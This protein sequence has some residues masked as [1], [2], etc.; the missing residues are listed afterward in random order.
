MRSRSI[1]P[2]CLRG[3]PDGAHCCGLS[4]HHTQTRFLWLPLPSKSPSTTRRRGQGVESVPH[5]PITK[6][7]H[8]PLCIRQCHASDCTHTPTRERRQPIVCC[9]TAD[10]VL[11]WILE[12]RCFPRTMEDNEMA[13]F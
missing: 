9:A 6:A 5:S 3:R 2:L 11:A 13:S 8:P 4:R 12:A 1:A 10:A 7:R